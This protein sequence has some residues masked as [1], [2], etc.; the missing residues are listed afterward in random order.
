VATAGGG[1]PAE[2]ESQ[3]RY[4][5]A[6][7]PFRAFVAMPNASAIVLLAA[8][9]AALIWANSP[10]SSTYEDFW[11]TKL[12]ISLGDHTLSLDLRHWVNDGLMAFFFFVVGL[13]IRREFDMGEL[14]ERHRLATPV[15]AAIGGML[16]PA[17]LYLAFNAGS[18]GAKGW[19]IVI[20]TDTAFA[21]GLLAVF[22][23][24]ASPRIRV[25][26]LTMV[27]VDD[28]IA[29]L[30]IAFAYTDDLSVPALLLAFALFG[31][32]FFMRSAGVRNG[33]AY[34]VVAAAIWV[35]TFE[36]GVHPTI[37]G[38]ALGLIVTAYP[39]S[40][41]DLE[42]V[43]TLWRLFREQPT[44]E[45]ARETSASL[46]STVSPNERLQHLID[47]WTSLLIVPV[48]ALANAGID[49]DSNSLERA[50]TSPITIGIIVG[51][52]VGK[53]VG[54]IAATWLGTRSWLGRFPLTVPWPSL[55]GAS[56]V[57][58]IGFTVSLLIADLSFTGSRLEEAK[59]GIL[60]ASILATVLSA[61]V[62]RAIQ[63]LPEQ[64]RRSGE[65]RVVPPI[66]DL[67]DPVDPD[68]DHIRGNE[69][70]RV[71]LLEYA[72]YEC[73]FCGQTEP[74]VRELLRTHGSELRYVFRHLPLVDVHEHAELAAE[75][76]EAAGAEG[77]FWEM[78]D[79]L[80][81]EGGLKYDDLLEHARALGLDVDQF[82]ADLNN[83]R[84]ALR[85][86]RDIESAEYSGVAGTPTF[87]VNG[88]RLHGA[89]DLDRL[90]AIIDHEMK[91]TARRQ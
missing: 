15:I 32:V 72:D 40:R 34:F 65:Q 56:T 25:F 75:A 21:L 62:F 53:Q 51:L 82:A 48:F 66:I 7:A 70:A 45:F 58:G 74:I 88:R 36:S 39:P 57:A 22:G 54:V 16:V 52:V 78:H 12:T 35:A 77:R 37:A 84:F 19:G 18:S 30:V 83:R 8:A 73:P 50:A 1:A 33:V 85:V 28:I 64:L 10:W 69:D 41:A 91:I 63:L 38:V 47:P 29:L 13:E 9:L 46:R 49:I 17:A 44:P 24:G 20:G 87:F 26:L 71:T 31:V 79:R 4:S 14:R 76:S 11:T 90:W 42:R 23:R 60:G 59:L 27:I 61:A 3:T 67:A 43:S 89:Y 55:W 2:V 5:R 80:F 6:A 68:R 86:A 81:S